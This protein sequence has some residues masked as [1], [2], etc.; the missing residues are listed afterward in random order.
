MIL[1]CLQLL[2]YQIYN[3]TYRDIK[4]KYHNSDFFSSYETN[5]LTLI[6][7]HPE[8]KI[9]DVFRHLHSYLFRIQL[10]SNLSYFKQKK[11]CHLTMV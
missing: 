10:N 1:I 9:K 5:N 2:T 4:K 8:K 7:S 3:N 11:K 6:F